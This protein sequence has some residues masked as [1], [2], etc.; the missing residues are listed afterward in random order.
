MFKILSISV[1][2]TIVFAI[3]A[4]FGCTQVLVQEHRVPER[5]L[6]TEVL[7]K[8]LGPDNLEYKA[9]IKR[10]VLDPKDWEIFVNDNKLTAARELAEFTFCEQVKKGE[11]VEKN[12]V[13]IGEKRYSCHVLK[14][15][16][17]GAFLIG[18]HS[19]PYFLTPPGIWFNL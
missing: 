7:F 15:I 14:T 6:S 11:Q 3:V 18:N 8:F 19:C 17:D 10:N 4:L 5:V 2:F 9:R 13:T 1:F 16:S 12:V